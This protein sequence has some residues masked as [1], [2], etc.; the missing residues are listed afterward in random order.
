ML[1]VLLLAAL[2]CNLPSRGSIQNLS[3]TSTATIQMDI[4]S[5]T[6]SPTEDANTLQEENIELVTEI[7]PAPA[8]STL[9]P[10]LA[11]GKPTKASREDSD[12]PS[13]HAVDGNLDTF[14]NTGQQ[15]PPQWIEVNLGGPTEITT[16]RLYVSQFP[17]G[18]TVHELLVSKDRSD[19][20]VV[21]TFSGFT[22]DGQVLEFTPPEPLDGYKFLMIRTIE[23]P[24]WISWKEIEVIGRL[25]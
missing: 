19:Y 20:E 18:E 22:E 3:S 6:V 14:W 9:E 8:V 10:N 7:P 4:P 23:S 1:L 21:Q 12:H 5:E 16:I 2:A 11:S 25:K 17:D 13:E 15:Y 24:S